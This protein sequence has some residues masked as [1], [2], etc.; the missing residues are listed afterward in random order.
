MRT[1][2]APALLL[3]AWT[4]CLGQ[5]TRP[6]AAA[7]TQPAEADLM[8]K[9]LL[10]GSRPKPAI[11]PVQYPPNKSTDLMATRPAAMPT[12][13][14]REGTYLVDRVGRLS[15]TTEGQ[16]ELTLE[17]DGSGLKDPPL[18]ILP[19]LKLMQM[20]TAIRT[21]SRDLKFRVTGMI[22]EYNGRNHILLEKMV[23]V[24]TPAPSP[25]DR[26]KK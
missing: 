5:T 2:L 20:E 3:L 19:N 8:L 4:L 23:V 11:D 15:R 9:Q 12:G 26:V 16:A 6:D 1:L 17:S 7:A 25:L 13:L 24:D 18:V 21:S 10:S 22:T 14:I